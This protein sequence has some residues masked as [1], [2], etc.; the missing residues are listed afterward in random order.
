MKAAISTDAG[1]VSAHFGRCP[2]FTIVDIEN[3]KVLHKEVIENP[4]HKPGFIPQFLHERGVDCIV[5]GGMGG[6]ATSLFNEFG[7]RTVV[8]ISGSIDSVIGMLSTGELKSG[9]STCQP[10]AGKG[11][12]IEKD[13]CDHENEET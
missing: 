11:Y 9:E 3:G 7:I 5:A 2:A 8:G 4:G 13:E 10:G 12:G 6:R 1:S